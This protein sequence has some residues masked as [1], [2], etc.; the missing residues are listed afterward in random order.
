VSIRTAKAGGVKRPRRSWPRWV[1]ALFAVIAVTIVFLARDREPL[2]LDERA[3]SRLPGRFVVLSHG[4]TNYEVAGPEKGP[5]V[6]LIP[7]ISIPRAVFGRTLAPLAEAG[8]RVISFDLYGRGFSARPHV[9]YDAPLFNQQI[10]DLLAAL[11]VEGSVTLIGLASGGLQ[12][13][14]Y[15]DERPSRVKSL[16]LIAP[17]GV[18]G[19]VTGFVRLVRRPIVGELTGRLVMN[20]VGQR[21]WEEAPK[22]LGRP[23]CGRGRR[24]AVPG[25]ARVQRLLA[26]A[27]ILDREPSDQ[28]VERSVS[29][30]RAAGNADARALGHQRPDHSHA[31][32]SGGAEADAVRDLH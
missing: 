6:L 26:G 30:N 29:S 4:P 11:H 28:R 1:A 16:V 2:A 20:A 19:P 13:M 14:L 9:R 17:D 5:V 27:G 3:V 21:R 15:A 25:A 12:A 18:D 23:S 10:D 8:Y 32:G 31:L 7:G 24:R 22:L